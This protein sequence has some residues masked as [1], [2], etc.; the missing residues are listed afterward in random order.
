MAMKMKSHE[1]KSY[2]ILKN[3]CENATTERSWI[4]LNLVFFDTVDMSDIE[5]GE[6]YQEGCNPQVQTE[7][8]RPN[9]T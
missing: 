5:I 2:E 1:N 9:W 3:S 6:N 4:F 7:R 8:S